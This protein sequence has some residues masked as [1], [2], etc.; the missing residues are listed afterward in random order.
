[1]EKEF[2][3]IRDTLDSLDKIQMDHIESFDTDLMP[4][5]ECQ[6]VE[7][8]KEF[9]KLEK[10]IRQFISNA[11]LDSN[12]D[13]ESMILFFIERINKLLDQN[14]TLEKRV[15]AHRDTLQETMKKTSRGKQVIG[16]Y[17]SPSSVS[18]RP[19]AISLTN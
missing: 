18:N 13:T 9:N 6:L 15:K 4:N 17:G 5:L 14:K 1:M 12:P 10:N 7:R 3:Q 11:G 19:R 2:R 8:K 16:S